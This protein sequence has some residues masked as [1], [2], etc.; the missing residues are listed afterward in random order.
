MIRMEIL[1]R[2]M[3]AATVKELDQKA[4]NAG[5][6]RQEFIKGYLER[7]AA[8][9]AFRNEREEY[10][11][12]VKNMAKIIGNNT[13]QMQKTMQILEDILEHVKEESKNGSR[14]TY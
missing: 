8:V 6:S 2:D 7:L 11:S 9:D 14:K 3:S 1:I 4:R 10:A 12:L 5:L 13:E